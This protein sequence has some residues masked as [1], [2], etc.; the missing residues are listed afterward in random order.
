MNDN[1][2]GGEGAFLRPGAF[3]YMSQVERRKSIV[4]TLMANEAPASVIDL[5]CGD[6]R[7][8]LQFLDSATTVTLLDTSPSML[9]LASN[10]VPYRYRGQVRFV[11]SSI[12]DLAESQKYDLVLAVGVLAHV[13]DLPGT[14]SKIAGLLSDNGR[15]I[16]QLTDAATIPGAVITAWSHLTSSKRGYQLNRLTEHRVVTALSMD[17]L[18][19]VARVQYSA[20]YGTF[21]SLTRRFPSPPLTAVARRALDPWGAEKL[22]VFRLAACR[23]ARQGG[24]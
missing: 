15:A 19:L 7:V 2:A 24:S 18:E 21:N 10:S 6:G 12:A 1:V 17:G 8:S 4:R 16:L 9:S 14:L 11:V 20:L 22:L 3:R 23:E 13:T 5:G